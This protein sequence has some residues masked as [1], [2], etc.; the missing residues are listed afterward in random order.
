MVNSMTG[1]GR[2][3][4]DSEQRE[5]TAEVK[6]VNHRYLDIAIKVPR[7]Y[8]FLEDPIKKAASA[9]IERGK[10]DI[11]VSIREKDGGNVAITPNLGV[12]EGYLGALDQIV[13]RFGPRVDRGSDSLPSGIDLLRLPDAIS[14]DKTEVGEEV[15]L[16]EVMAAL[17]DALAAHGEMR[18]REGANLCQDILSRAETIGRIANEIGRRSPERVEEYREKLR[19]RMEEL[20]DGGELAT[21]RVLAEA[22][23]FADKVSVTEELVRLNSHLGQLSGMIH[24]G[25][26]VG[27]KLDFLIQELNRE[28]NTIGSKANDVEIAGLVVEAKAEIEKIRE[29][30]Q[31]LE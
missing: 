26:A 5:I 14:V 1:Y 20:L 24:S 4:L 10:V 18:K 9:A 30:V 27:R 3:K 25:K 29:Q 19:V 12:I 11:F 28:V 31:N 21:Q 16:G 6:S 23:L 22:A 15:L 8:G 2:G 13:D 7:V 17:N